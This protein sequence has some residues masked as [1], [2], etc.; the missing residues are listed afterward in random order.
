[1][2]YVAKRDRPLP[3]GPYRQQLYALGAEVQTFELQL[4]SGL[5]FELKG[6]PGFGIEA[7][8][9]TFGL[10]SFNIRSDTAELAK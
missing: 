2:R 9:L 10:D 6:Q 8:S 5:A 4:E 7:E 3:Y 1:V